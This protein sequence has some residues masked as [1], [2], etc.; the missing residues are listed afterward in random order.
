MVYGVFGYWVGTGALVGGR[1]GAYWS[2]GALVVGLIPFLCISF[3]QLC[4]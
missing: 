4:L 3:S 1:L 2:K